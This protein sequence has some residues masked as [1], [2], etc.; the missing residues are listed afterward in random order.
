MFLRDRLKEE[1][2]YPELEAHEA[3]KKIIS[4]KIEDMRK[5]YNMHP[6]SGAGDKGRIVFVKYHPDYKKIKIKKEV[7][8]EASNIIASDKTSK[9][10]TI[11]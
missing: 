4:N 2:K 5:N 8:K 9:Y 10:W 7:I 6:Y 1:F 11:R 3:A